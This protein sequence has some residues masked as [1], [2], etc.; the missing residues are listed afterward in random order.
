MTSAIV[1]LLGFYGASRIRSF[2][3]YFIIIPLFLTPLALPLLNFFGLTDSLL[4]Y[5][6][7]TQASLNLLWASFHTISKGDMLYSLACLPVFLILS[8]Y[9]AA[10]SFRRHILVSSKK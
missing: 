4:L 9:L 8:Y 6:L 1:T 3:Q 10:Y 7:P 5:M 2:N